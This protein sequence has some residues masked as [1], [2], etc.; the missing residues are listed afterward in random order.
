M[1]STLSTLLNP[2]RYNKRIRP[3]IGKGAV[4]VEINFF[5][6]SIGPVDEMTQVNP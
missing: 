5:V 2:N 4:T 3:G 1:S 6:N